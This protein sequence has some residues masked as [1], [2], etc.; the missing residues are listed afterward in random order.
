MTSTRALYAQQAR[1]LTHPPVVLP[2]DSSTGLVTHGPWSGSDVHAL[3]EAM[4]LAHLHAGR[5]V[6][7]HLGFR[8]P[9]WRPCKRT[10]IVQITVQA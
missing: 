1:T 9:W 4:V 10:P 3:A 5:D 7:Y 6:V 2:Y 8:R